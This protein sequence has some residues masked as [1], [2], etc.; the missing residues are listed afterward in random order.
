MLKF[1]S[2][3]SSGSKHRLPQWEGRRN[4]QICQIYHNEASRENSHL[5][6]F[7]AKRSHWV[8][9]PPFMGSLS[10]PTH[11]ATFPVQYL[12]DTHGDLL[13]PSENRIRFSQRKFNLFLKKI[14]HHTRHIWKNLSTIFIQD[15]PF[16]QKQGTAF[17]CIF[18]N[19]AEIKN[20]SSCE[21]WYSHYWLWPPA[22]SFSPSQTPWPGN[23]WLFSATVM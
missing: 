18:L 23:I 7:H 2:G 20:Q 3:K 22:L 19:F 10:H 6:W 21:I 12:P 17:R 15:I 8:I 1:H 9:S 5:V 14:I 4:R 11:R 13:C 16:W